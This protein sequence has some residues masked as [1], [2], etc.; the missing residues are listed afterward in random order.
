MALLE[1][2]R[3]VLRRTKSKQAIHSAL[4]RELGAHA[5]WV[6]RSEINQFGCRFLLCVA[7]GLSHIVLFR[8]SDQ[9][10][11]RTIAH[12]PAS[13]CATA[14]FSC[15]G[16]GGWVGV[17]VVGAATIKFWNQPRPPNTPTKRATC[18]H[19][20]RRGDARGVALDEHLALRLGPGQLLLVLHAPARPL[21]QHLHLLVHPE[22][23]VDL[24]DRL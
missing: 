3:R 9:T 14:P 18:V 10:S 23:E 1:D 17:H 15:R 11:T 16:A 7:L 21:V 13:F 24:L 19:E 4:E 20:G 12:P 2:G 22:E 6:A 5:G 8:A